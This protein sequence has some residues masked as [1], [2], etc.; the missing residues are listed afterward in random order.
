MAIAAVA[1]ATLLATF[2]RMRLSARTSPRCARRP[3][4][5]ASIRLVG[6]VLAQQH[7][8]LAEGWRSPGLDVLAG[9]HLTTV[10]GSTPD[11][12]EVITEPQ[13]ARAASASTKIVIPALRR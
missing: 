6:A 12:R 9:A 5:H 4:S 7:D 8:E 1:S 10:P 13:R 11:S 3:G 2:P